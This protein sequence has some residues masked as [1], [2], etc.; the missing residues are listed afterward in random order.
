[1]CH[2]GRE[3]EQESSINWICSDCGEYVRGGCHCSG[4]GCHGDV[5]IVGH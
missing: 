3:E 1:M 4:E 2:F 5:V